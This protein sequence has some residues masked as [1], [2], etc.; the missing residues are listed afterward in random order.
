MAD[1]WS[2]VEIDSEEVMKLLREG[3]RFLEAARA[4]LEAHP[5]EASP[6][7]RPTAPARSAGLAAR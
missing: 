4:Y 6:E 7:V 1:Y 5:P 3:R 2:R